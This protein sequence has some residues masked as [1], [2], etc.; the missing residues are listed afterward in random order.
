MLCV[1]YNFKMMHVSKFNPAEA[2]PVYVNCTA[3]SADEM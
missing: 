2:L 1:Y 3:T